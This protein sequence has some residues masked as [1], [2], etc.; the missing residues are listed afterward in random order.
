MPNE[1]PNGWT[2]RTIAAQALGLVEPAVN[3]MT[4]CGG[5]TQLVDS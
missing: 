3:V 5:R 1:A 2:P 4:C